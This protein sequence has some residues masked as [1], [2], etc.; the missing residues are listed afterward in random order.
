M[1][2]EPSG[3]PLR[4]AVT[5]MVTLAIVMRSLCQAGRQGRLQGTPGSGGALSKPTA[6]LAAPEP[7]TPLVVCHALHCCIQPLQHSQVCMPHLLNENSII[8]VENPQVLDPAVLGGD[9]VDG[10]QPKLLVVTEVGG[11]RELRGGLRAGSRAGF[12]SA[13]GAAGARCHNTFGLACTWRRLGCWS[14]SIG[15]RALQSSPPQHPLVGRLQTS[16]YSRPHLQREALEP[17]IVNRCLPP[18]QSRLHFLQQRPRQRALQGDLVAADAGDAA[19]VASG[20][21]TAAGRHGGCSGRA[22]GSWQRGTS[23]AGSRQQPQC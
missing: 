10:V 19:G 1:P 3:G 5:S 6:Q 12:T 21:V 15:Q 23:A 14:Y 18:N 4:G 7:Q 2:R 8:A 17:H 22:V 9:E 20:V 16:Q 13:A 11:P